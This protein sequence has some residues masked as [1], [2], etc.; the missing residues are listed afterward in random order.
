V[1]LAVTGGVAVAVAALANRPTIVVA[2][3]TIVDAVTQT[4][5][6]P[7]CLRRAHYELDAAR[8]ELLKERLLVVGGENAL[9][10]GI[11]LAAVDEIDRH[12]VVCHHWSED[13]SLI[14]RWGGL[15]GLVCSTI[16][17]EG[18]GILRGAAGEGHVDDG[19]LDL[20]G[21]HGCL[22]HGRHARGDA[23][24]RCESDGVLHCGQMIGVGRDVEIDAQ[25]LCWFRLASEHHHFRRRSSNLYTFSVDDFLRPFRWV[26][27]LL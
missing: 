5:N 8:V 20:T 16:R 3:V 6:R 14:G 22:G 2:P 1:A 23:K 11:V 19:I 18:H 24:G 21:C 4:T 25:M 9:L 7:D 13:G 26:R 17:D 27:F 10:E 12:V 15:T